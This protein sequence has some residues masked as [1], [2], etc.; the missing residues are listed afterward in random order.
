MESKNDSHYD[1][2]HR[3]RA[4][5]D[6]NQSEHNFDIKDKSGVELTF[7]QKLGLMCQTYLELQDE[8]SAQAIKQP[9]R[10]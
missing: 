10:W 3:D 1:R 7:A 5:H 4:K 9:Y 2:D 6:D 8:N